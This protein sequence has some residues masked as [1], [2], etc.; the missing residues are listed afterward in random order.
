LIGAVAGVIGGAVLFVLGA[1]VVAAGI[2]Y[3]GSWAS[4]VP[5]ALIFLL[6]H[7]AISYLTGL[8]GGLLFSRLRPGWETTGAIIGGLVLEIW[9]GSIFAF[10]RLPYLFLPKFEPVAIT[11]G[12]GHSLTHHFVVADDFSEADA[13]KVG[14]F[15]GTRHSYDPL[16]IRFYCLEGHHEKPFRPEYMLYQYTR[17]S[18]ETSPIIIAPPNSIYPDQGKACK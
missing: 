2:E 11:S 7:F 12:S 3:H 10:E 13:L 1:P 15:Y 4:L 16:I 6:L 18:K 14:N 17:A 5:L 9:L 8:L